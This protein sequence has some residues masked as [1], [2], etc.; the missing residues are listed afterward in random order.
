[1]FK[2]W[3]ISMLNNS[4]NRKETILHNS[5]YMSFSTWLDKLTNGM[6]QKVP[7][8]MFTYME[9]GHVDKVPGERMNQSLNSLKKTGYPHSK[10]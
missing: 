3:I 5:S 7:K 9:I 8:Q 1:M 2:K 4:E 6:E 10:K